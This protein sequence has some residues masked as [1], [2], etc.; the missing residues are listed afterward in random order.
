[1]ER[2]NE[3]FNIT[4]FS[5]LRNKAEDSNIKWRGNK[6]T[7]Y[8]RVKNEANYRNVEFNIPMER[9][10]RKIHQTWE[11]QNFK[12]VNRVCDKKK[13]DHPVGGKIY[14]CIQ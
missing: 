3:R 13:L 1:M 2:G 4:Q 5:R 7:G 10:V 14:V 6:R 12:G 8:C 11:Q 9:Q